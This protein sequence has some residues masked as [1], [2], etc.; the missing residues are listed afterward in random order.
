LAVSVKLTGA[1]AATLGRALEELNTAR[2][3]FGLHTIDVSLTL[4]DLIEIVGR[5]AKVWAAANR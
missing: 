1:G 3:Q 4:G 2:P 5:Q